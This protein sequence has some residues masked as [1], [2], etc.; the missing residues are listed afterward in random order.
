M[1]I[2][3]ISDLE[4]KYVSEVLNSQF[5]T[6]SGNYMTKKLEESFAKKF[7]SRYAISFINGTSTMHASLVA[8]GVGK[9]DEVIVPPLTMAS[10]SLAVIHCGAIPVFADIDPK[11]WT[12]DP[13]S[14][15]KSITARTKAIIPVAIYGLL[16][17]MD[18]IMDV[19][20]KY[21][22]FVLED[23]AQAV[24]SYYKGKIGGS[25]GHASSFSFQSSK[26]ITSGEGG[27]VITNDEKLANKIREM[28]S[29]G[30]AGLGASKGK[31]TKDSIQDPTYDRHVSIGWNYRIPE[32]CAAVALGQLERVEELVEIRV[33]V[34]QMYE[35]AV[36]ECNWLCPQFVPEEYINS[37]WTY[38]LKLDNED[39]FSWYD[40]RRKYMEFGGEGI[41]AAWKL[42][43]L[44]P[45]FYRAKLSASQLQQFDYGLCPVAERIQ[46]KLLQF[47]TNYWDLEHAAHAVEALKKTIDYFDNAFYS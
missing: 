47:K 28:N 40:F 15:E 39:L 38:V 5:S 36:D 2:E 11:T 32:L 17:D 34:A 6:S 14:I 21:N 26:H 12:I 25:I 23:D 18:A 44:E 3:R 24:L 29:L 19:A 20:N 22:L 13:N 46:P 30:Y 31:I 4:K 1:H 42:T 35:K 9:D 41:Y 10:T 7:N 37:Y 43:Y 33:K 27:M 45:V 16:P 8:A